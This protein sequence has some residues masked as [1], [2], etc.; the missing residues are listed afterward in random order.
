MHQTLYHAS[1]R[2]SRQT[3]IERDR[4]TDIVPMGEVCAAISPHS[5]HR[6]SRKRAYSGPS[7]TLFGGRADS[8][9]RARDFRHKSGRLACAAVAFA[10]RHRCVCAFFSGDPDVRLSAR[11]W[12][13][14]LSRSSFPRSANSPA[15]RATYPEMSRACRRLFGPLQ[16]L[17]W[18][19]SLLG[20]RVREAGSWDRACI[21]NVQVRICSVGSSFPS[22]TWISSRDRT[23]RLP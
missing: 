13:Q 1:W 9:R 16:E 8:L 12:K 23:R 22:R 7:M 3:T 5:R 20:S 18:T 2:I 15:A 21:E 19:S 14:V 4:E 10:L 6:P 17:W 11:R